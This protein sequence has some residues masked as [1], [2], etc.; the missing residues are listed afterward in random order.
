MVADLATAELEPARVRAL[1]AIDLIATAERL[2]SANDLQNVVALYREWIAHNPDN[3][4]LYAINFNL[5]VVLS[6]LNDFQGASA[7][8]AEA[9]RLNPGFPA[10][11]YQSRHRPGAP[12]PDRGRARAMVRGG[13]PARRGHRRNHRPQ[14]H[15]PQAAWPRAGQREPGQQRRRGAAAQPGTRPAPAG[16]AVP[17]AEPAPEAMRVAGGARPARPDARADGGGVFV[18]VARRLYRRPA[19]ATRGCRRLCPPRYRPPGTLVRARPSAPAGIA[20]SPGACGSA[21]FHPICASMRSA[22]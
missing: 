14:E 19:A 21:I 7:A 8:L 20:S 1:G 17:L 9:I 18:A 16:R 2:A 6:A 10:A 3:P 5:G 15:R 12:G 11:L 4:L 22:T 13:Q